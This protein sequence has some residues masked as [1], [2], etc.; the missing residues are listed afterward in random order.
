MDLS[1]QEPI[2]IL[3]ESSESGS[4]TSFEETDSEGEMPPPAKV[5]KTSDSFRRMKMTSRYYRRAKSGLVH[6]LDVIM[7]SCATKVLA[8]GRP[9]TASY[10]AVQDAV[11]M[12]KLCRVQALK[13]DP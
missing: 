3:G 2:T 11:G 13:R 6:F 10:F 7:D 9:L 8:C 1:E 4:D 12:C 5:A